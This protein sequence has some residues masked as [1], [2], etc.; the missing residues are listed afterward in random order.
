MT[1]QGK[2]AGLQP[3]VVRPWSIEPEPAPVPPARVP[4]G[5]VAGAALTP[6]GL[7]VGFSI[8]ALPFL[9][10]RSGISVDHVASMSATV[11]SPTFWGFLLNPLLDTGFS[12]QTYCWITTGTAAISLALAMLVLS[13]QHLVVT[14]SLLLLAELSAVLFASAVGGWTTE[15]VPESLRGSVGGWTNVANLGAG[16]LG[17]LAVMSFSTRVGPRW[18]GLALAL[19]VVAGAAPLLFFPPAKKSSF[20][21][22]QVFSDAMR[23]IWMASKRRECL[24]GFALFLA[25]ASAVAA[26]NLF[27]GLGKDFHSSPGTVIAVTGAGCAITASIGSLLGGFLSGRLPRGYVY[28][29]AGIAAGVCALTLA[30]TPHTQAAFV[31]GVLIY[32]GIAGVAYAAFTALGLQLVGHSSPVASTQLGLFA[33]ATNGAIVVMTWADGQGYRYSGVRG[34]LTVDGVAS[35]ATAIPL[36]FLVYRQLRRPEATTDKHVP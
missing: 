22:A 17:S 31:W 25:P 6:F 8:T 30:F 27:S 29:S 11:M 35:M 9:L 32:N 16:A 4:P 23:G 14:T 10:T 7:V 24:V 36:L 18:I 19:A 3:P 13:P 20:A 28:L 15:F 2:V 26:I 34:L 33:A 21:L 12:R 5:W 1:D